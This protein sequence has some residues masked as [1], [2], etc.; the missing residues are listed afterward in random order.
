MK[1][2]NR[3]ECMGK[4][5][6][7]SIGEATTEL[8]GVDGISPFGGVGNMLYGLYDG[9]DYSDKIRSHEDMNVIK[10]EKIDLYEKILNI[11]K[12][13]DTYPKHDQDV[14]VH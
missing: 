10:S 8:F 7:R 2:F 11:C 9:F 3:H 12:D 4:E 14:T 5:T 6:L 13:I 1:Y